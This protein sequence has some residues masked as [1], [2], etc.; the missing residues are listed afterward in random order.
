MPSKMLKNPVL[1]DRYYHVFNRANNNELVFR[2]QEDYQF[3]LKKLGEIVS[4]NIDILSFCLMPNHYHLLIKP[5][6][7]IKQKGDG[8]INE[9]LR[10]FFQIYVQY[11]NKKYSRK[12]SLF[13]KSFRRIEIEHDFYLKYLL[14]YI[15]F[16]PQKAQ[17]VKSFTEYKYSSFMYFS[18]GKETKLRKDIVLEWFGNCMQNFIDFHQECLNNYYSRGTPSHG[19]ESHGMESLLSLLLP[20]NSQL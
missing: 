9:C 3:F 19:M 12:G 7:Y 6:S 13:Y 16:N 8:S 18:S 11:I 17:L 4:E 1:P 15:H 10:K 14:F 2:D 5:K 20:E